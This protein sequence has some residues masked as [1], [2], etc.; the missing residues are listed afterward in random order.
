MQ[1]FVVASDNFELNHMFYGI[2]IIFLTEM[3]DYSGGQAR[4]RRY[5]RHHRDDNNPKS[6]LENPSRISKRCTDPAAAAMKVPL[7]PQS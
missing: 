3:S 4:F 2:C 1:L 5:R 6:Y 7:L